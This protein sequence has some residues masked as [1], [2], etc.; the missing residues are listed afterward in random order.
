MG[1]TWDTDLAATDWQGYTVEASGGLNW[2]LWLVLM[3][4][5][6]YPLSIGPVGKLFCRQSSE[7]PPALTAFYTPVL[8]VAGCCPLFE[9]ALEWYLF[10]VWHAGQ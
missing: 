4:G 10:R 6:A 9:G 7:D 1:K 8:R 5:L 2:C 3:L